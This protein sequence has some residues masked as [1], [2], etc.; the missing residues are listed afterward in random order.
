[1]TGS[2][3]QGA[4]A[5]FST[6]PLLAPA[7]EPSRP[8]SSYY[9]EGQSGAVAAAHPLASEAALAMLRA[10]GNA[11]DG[12][13]AASFVISVVRPQST[14]IGGG[15]FLLM[16][17][18]A[19]AES[20]NVKVYDFRERAPGGA[21]RQMYLDK[22]GQPS[23]FTYGGKTVPNASMNGHLAVGVPGIVAGLAEVHQEHGRL[24][25]ATVMAPAIKIA[26]EGFEV[27][28]GLAEAIAERAEILRV[29][30]ASKALFLPG[31]K[32]LKAGEKLVQKDL[33]WSL[34][35]IAK[36]GPKAFYQGEIARRIVKEMQR[37]RGLVTARDLI[38]YKVKH[39]EPVTGY[40]HGHKV[41]SMPPPSSGGVH[42]VEMLNM[43]AQDDL[44]ALG[45]GSV[46]YT[47]LVAETMRR[48]FADRAEFLGDTDFVK[49]PVQMLIS[50]YYAVQRRKTINPAAATP[51]K[52]VKAG[53]ADV[54]EHPSTT[55][56]SVVDK[57]GM[58]VATTQ[59][60]NYTFGSCVVA[61]GTGIVLND[62]MDDFS[63]KPGVPNAFGLVGNDAN[64]VA[65][66]KTMLSSMSPTLVFRP[67]GSFMMALGSPGGPRI[68]SATFQTILNVI[69]HKMDYRT[70][71]H[72]ARIHHQWLP[73][74]LV[75]ESGGLAPDVEAEL[76]KMGHATV[77]KGTIGDV[78]LV[79]KDGD[80]LIGVSDRRSEGAPRG[81]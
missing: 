54:F 41:V 56:L 45:H 71:V 80:K 5:F 4:D 18:R 36:D 19:T 15:G 64:A 25:W 81:F 9:A 34:G 39:R 17:S 14:G 60:V 37:G 77:A 24:P 1:M 59:T 23:S 13:V 31:G 55:H 2:A 12:A 42:I 28:P 65:A 63:I 26:K 51:S 47:H 58:A 21:S 79:A 16:T 6:A 50:P 76:R 49:V 48:A 7:A 67:D 68:I 52:D 78:Q 70:A 33:A 72:A 74:Q 3:P 11:V 22:A 27:Y 32:P 35:Q 69:D 73:D 61:E 10:G 44:R 38:N 8:A 75:F 30:P 20:S 66:N 29:F 43:L 46:A 53:T 62:E 40:Y 57:D